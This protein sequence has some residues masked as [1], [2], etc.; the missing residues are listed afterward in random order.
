MAIVRSGKI[1]VFSADEMTTDVILASACLPTL[2]QA[3]EFVDP[4][5]GENEAYWDGGYTG[6]PALFPLFSESLPDDIVIVNINPLQREEV[7]RTTQTI[8]NRINEISF[9]TSLFRELRAISFVQR[10]LES[11]TLLP[12]TMKKIHVHMI[13]DDELMNDL[14]VSTK[15]IPTPMLLGKLKAAGRAAT[16]KFLEDS[17]ASIGVKSSVDLVEMF[18]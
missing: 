9:N 1:R 11:G 8:Q 10:L 3:V 16:E 14:N 13:A 12:G 15:L 5:S 17:T 6:N 4:R 18:G 2:F 7:P